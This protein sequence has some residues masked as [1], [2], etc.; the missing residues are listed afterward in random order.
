MY[1]FGPNEIVKGSDIFPASAV[2]MPNSTEA[3]SI[4]INN[5][6]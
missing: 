6:I 1:E 2:A 5:D 4:Y 3:L